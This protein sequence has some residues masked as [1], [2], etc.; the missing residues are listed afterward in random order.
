[1][2]E[3]LNKDIYKLGDKDL[4][5]SRS[6]NDSTRTGYGFSNLIS[7]INQT[8]AH[9][10]RIFFFAFL[11]YINVFRL[12]LRIHFTACL[13]S[14]YKSLIIRTNLNLRNVNKIYQKRRLKETY[15]LIF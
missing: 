7:A 8:N 11:L 4:K 15:R 3:A 6:Y 12:I 10:G 5:V 14:S 2:D 13:L 1:M 9:A